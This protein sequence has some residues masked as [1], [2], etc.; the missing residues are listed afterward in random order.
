ML[1]AVLARAFPNAETEVEQ[2]E[3]RLAVDGLANNWPEMILKLAP[4]FEQRAGSPFDVFD[5]SDPDVRAAIRRWG[6]KLGLA[7]HYLHTSH[8]VPSA[9][10]VIV[11]TQTNRQF[12]EDGFPPC[13]VEVMHGVPELKR[14][15][16]PLG[17]QF[18]YLYSVIAG[19]RGSILTCRL[20]LAMFLHLFVADDVAEFPVDQREAAVRPFSYPSASPGAQP[21][22]AARADRT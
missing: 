11:W 7:L 16:H 13:L 1:I 9:G 3:F 19:G 6:G 18:S 15:N 8:I 17:D 4:T 5:L 21:G 20:R 14:T 10:G 12:H 22:D 2:R